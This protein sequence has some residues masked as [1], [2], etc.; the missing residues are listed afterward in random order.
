LFLST[1]SARVCVAGGP[2]P[3]AAGPL[4]GVAT[5][6]N[7]AARGLESPLFAVRE[8]ASQRLVDAQSPAVPV[9]LSVAKEENLEAAV[10]A[11]GILEAIYVSGDVKGDVATID[12]AE[13]ALDELTRSGRPSVADRAEVVLESHYDIRERRAVAEI[14]RLHG[15]PVFG[16]LGAVPNGWNGRRHP[17]PPAVDRSGDPSKEKGELTCLIVGPKWTGADEGLKH[18]ARLKRLRLLYRIQGCP[19]SDE[20]I[21]RLRAAIPGLNVEERGAAKLGISHSGPPAG[22]GGGCVIHETQEGEAA[23]NAGLRPQDRIVQF[24]SH[25]VD[26]FST[27]IK[28]LRS[29]K[30]GETVDCVIVRGDQVPMTVPVTLTGWD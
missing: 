29:Y 3:S 19:V 20:G 24:G 21:G 22:E 18:V 15:R 26:D 8:S 9:L 7:E 14:E 2:V 25:R 17:A 10:R 6:L 28:L 11:I 16:E 27:L 12:G 30:P 1:I 4:A 13:F 23:S 5:S